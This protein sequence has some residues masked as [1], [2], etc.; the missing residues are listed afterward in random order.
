MDRIIQS[1]PQQTQADDLMDEQ[2]LV[3]A[4]QKRDQR[5]LMQL[6]DHYSGA[7]YGVIIRIV[8]DRSLA[9]DVLQETMIKIWDRF[10]AYESNKGRLFTWMV[11]IARNAAIDATRSRHFKKPGAT[12]IEALTDTANGPQTEQAI[13]AIGL[14]ERVGRLR[15]EHQVVIELL[16]FQQYTHAEAAKALNIPLGTVKTRARNAIRQLRTVLSSRE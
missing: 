4:L 16:Y 3:L 7:L 10:S 1:K 13:D 5:A 2:Q 12:S 15:E 14:R 8:V 6:Y 9:E 11:R